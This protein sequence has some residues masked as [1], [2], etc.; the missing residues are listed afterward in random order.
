MILPNSRL[1]V[2][3]FPTDAEKRPPVERVERFQRQAEKGSSLLEKGLGLERPRDNKL[4]QRTSAYHLGS[5]E[6]PIVG[7]HQQI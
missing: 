6:R 4:S 1:G 3:S 7:Y 5:V 2:V